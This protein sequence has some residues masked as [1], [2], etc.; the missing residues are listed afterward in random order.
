MDSNKMQITDQMLGID[1]YHIPTVCEKCGGVMTFKG[2]GE[3]ECEDCGATAYDDYGKVRAYLEKH[4]GATAAQVEAA[5]SVK[6]KTIRMMLKESRL[7][8]A[9]DSKAFMV[10]ENCGKRIRSGRLCTQC[11]ILYHRSLE[12]QQRRSQN[13]NIKG[14]GLTKGSG[15]E[16]EK[17]FRRE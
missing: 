1:H 7:E 4:K 13:R 15:E 9:E 17:R 16:G 8:V 5:T 3:Y 10:C 6:Q 14:H 2:V 11:E 12:E